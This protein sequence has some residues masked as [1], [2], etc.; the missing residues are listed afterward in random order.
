VYWLGY[1]SRQVGQFF[2]R[3]RR[4]ARPGG[5]IARPSPKIGYP[6]RNSQKLKL[7]PKGVSEETHVPPSRIHAIATDVHFWIPV[8]VLVLGAMLLLVLR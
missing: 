1:V 7:L 3:S 5:R 8:V 6:P 4:Y 2:M